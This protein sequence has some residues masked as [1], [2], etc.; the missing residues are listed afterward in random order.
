MQKGCQN[1]NAD[2]YLFVEPQIE[3]FEYGANKDKQIIMSPDSVYRIKHPH[4]LKT[5]YD[6]N[7]SAKTILLLLDGT[8]TLNDIRRFL[9][10]QYSDTPEAINIA[11]D[12]FFGMISSFEDI[13]IIESSEPLSRP[14]S[15]LIFDNS[16]P[17]VVSLELTNQCNLKCQHCYGN[18][19]YAKQKV[20]VSLVD[21]KNLLNS[22]HQIGVTTIELTGGDPSVYPFTSEAIDLAFESGVTNITYLSNGLLL[23]DKVFNSLEKYKNNVLVQIDLHSLDDAYC[24]WFTGTA[25]TVKIIKSNIEKLIDADISVFVAMIVTPKNINHIIDVAEWAHSV[26]ASQ[27]GISPVVELGRAY[28]KNADLLLTSEEEIKLFNKA[29]NRVNQE[30]PDFL[31]KAQSPSDMNRQNCGA[32][33]PHATID[34]AGNIKICPM[35]ELPN[36]G[37]PLGNVFEKPIKQIYDDNADFITS[38]TTL[39]PPNFFQ[40]DCQVCEKAV[41]CHTC[42]ARGLLS[43][44]E[45]GDKCSWYQDCVNS[46]IKQKLGLRE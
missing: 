33:F 26:G 46:V 9:I 10:T 31:K 23:S 4:S 17:S 22:L 13:K 11:L 37:N 7:E 36:F 39:L 29:I 44:Q 24:K 27:L 3:I 32:I 35:D 8:K 1:L 42:V 41:F 21:L 20:E 45:K 19:G 5:K 30:Y 2:N 34:S 14:I 16:Y 40:E 38:F 15:H 28:G 18:F 12:S 25:N 6:L 43:A